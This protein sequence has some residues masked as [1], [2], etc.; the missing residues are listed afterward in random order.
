LGT[1][2]AA[3]DL[4]EKRSEF[5][6]SRP[7]AIVAGELLSAGNRDFLRPNDEKW[8]RWRNMLHSGFNHRISQTYQETQSLESKILLGELLEEPQ[9]YVRHIQRYNASIITSVTYGLRV[10]S[11]DEWIVQ[12]NLAAV[13]FFI[14]AN[15]PG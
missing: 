15:T 1:A 6:S 7:R 5:Y 3:W 11:V 4:L 2:Q 14:K 12:E 8:R 9:N 10:D 13:T